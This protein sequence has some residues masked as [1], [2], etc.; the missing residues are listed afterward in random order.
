MM[1][2]KGC[3]NI[4]SCRHGSR[5]VRI[6]GITVTEDWQLKIVLTAAHKSQVKDMRSQETY[7]RCHGLFSVILR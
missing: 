7:K 5:T 4:N 6:E 3:A 1:I 2:Q